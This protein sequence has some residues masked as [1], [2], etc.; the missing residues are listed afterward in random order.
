MPRAVI[1]T[2]IG[3]ALL[4]PALA[5][6]ANTCRCVEWLREGMRINIR[7]DAWTIRGNAPLDTMNIGD[8]L[9]TREG[10]GH[11]ALVV[12]FEGS[13][14]M[15]TYTAPEYIRILEANYERCRVTTR[16]IQW[17]DTKIRGIYRPTTVIH[18]SPTLTPSSMFDDV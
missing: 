9:L 3:V 7:G 18:S 5:S 2:L 10:P 1:A 14:D 17:G 16:L 12:G 15:G 4:F 13:Q 6:A 11:A 8:V